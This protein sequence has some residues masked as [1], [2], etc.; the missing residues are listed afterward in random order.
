MVKWILVIAI[1][2][3]T[4][5]ETNLTFAS[6]ELCLAAELQL[7]TRMADTFNKS[8]S[9]YNEKD[10]LFQMRRHGLYNEMTCIPHNEN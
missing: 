9:Q 6:L 8:A 3:N 1:F 7:R 10:K 5:V 4:P 2:G